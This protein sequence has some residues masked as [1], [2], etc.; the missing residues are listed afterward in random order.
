[1][2]SNYAALEWKVVVDGV[3]YP[4]AGETV[5]LFDIT[6]ADPTDGTGAVALA[7]L[8]TDGAGHMAGGVF[9]GLAVG[10]VVRFSVVR[11]ADGLP[12]SITQ[13]TT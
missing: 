1:M 13:V 9:A 3:E 10:R 6:D 5:Q 4:V 7:D 12:R 11:A 2:P 8:A